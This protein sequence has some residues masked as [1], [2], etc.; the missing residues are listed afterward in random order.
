[1][2]VISGEWIF[3]LVIFVV[4]VITIGELPFNIQ[5]SVCTF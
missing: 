3:A 2:G 4:I 1:M 5:S